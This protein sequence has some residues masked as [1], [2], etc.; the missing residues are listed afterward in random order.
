LKFRFSDCKGSSEFG[1]ETGEIPD[2]IKQKIVNDV[3]EN[4][5]NLVDNISNEEF[6]SR[7]YIL[8]EIKLRNNL[9]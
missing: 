8:F 9:K 2:D 7:G 4:L 1:T 5:E 3:R 6:E